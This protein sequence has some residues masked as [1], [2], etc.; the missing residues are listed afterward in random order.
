MI[1][2]LCFVCGR[3][4][5]ANGN[6]DDNIIFIIE[7]TKLYVP[8]VTWSARNNQN[9]SKPLSKTF[10]RSVYWNEYKT[11]SEKKNTTNEYRYFLESNFVEIN[12]LFV[13][14]YTNK[15]NNTKRFNTQKYLP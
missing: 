9:L 7:D 8:V 11:R 15:A 12:R 1:K 14:V 13:L 3:Y 6:N 4:W 5:Y 2:V 10:E